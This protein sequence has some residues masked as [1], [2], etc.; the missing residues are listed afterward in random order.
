MYQAG[1]KYILGIRPDHAGLV[2]DPCI[3]KAWGGFTVT[4]KCRGAEYRIA[5]KNPKNA[6]KGVAS[7]VVDGKPVE[8]NVI[9]WFDS[10]VHEVIA[11]LG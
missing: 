5:V 1:V 6:S 11:V 2:V 8:G 4:R 9:P 3:P 10:G 7:L